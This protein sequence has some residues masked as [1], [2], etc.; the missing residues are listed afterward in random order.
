MFLRASPGAQKHQLLR[1]GAVPV[2]RVT[3]INHLYKA[4]GSCRMKG[5]GSKA[6]HLYY[7]KRGK[8]TSKGLR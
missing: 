4:L 5:E 7:D 2:S 3:E 1:A 8:P 6:T